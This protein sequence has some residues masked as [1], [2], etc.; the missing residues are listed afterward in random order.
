MSFKALFKDALYQF[1][2]KTAHVLLKEDRSPPRNKVR[3]APRRGAKRPARG[4][5]KSLKGE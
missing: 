3:A 1:T 4:S 2:V 5:K